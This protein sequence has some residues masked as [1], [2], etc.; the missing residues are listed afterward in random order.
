[1]SVLEFIGAIGALIVLGALA[2]LLF[3]LNDWIRR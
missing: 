2:G 1:M 3:W